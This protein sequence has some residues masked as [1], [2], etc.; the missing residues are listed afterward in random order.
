MDQACLNTKGSY[1]CVPTPCPDDY[2]RDELSGQCIQM[3]SRQTNKKC[4]E[5]ATIA[6]TISYTVLSL[7]HFD[8]TAPILKLV[9]YD[10]RRIAI[11]H[12]QFSFY[13]T[14]NSDVFLLESLTH[15][16]GIVYLYAKANVKREK[17]YKLKITGQSYDKN[18]VQLEYITRFIIYIYII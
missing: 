1:L 4:T 6:Q 9:N 13:D 11:E 12:T 2:D 8:I 5:D 14:A 3:C 17:V 18:I 15:R 7:S 16:T 10:V